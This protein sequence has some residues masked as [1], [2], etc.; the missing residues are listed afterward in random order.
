[1]NRNMPR[2]LSRDELDAFE[3]DGV[4]LVKGM[5]DADWIERMSAALDVILD[6]PSERMGDLNPEGKPGK[7][8]V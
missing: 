2:P 8:R 4:A 1:M 6:T 7:V 5:F 3:R